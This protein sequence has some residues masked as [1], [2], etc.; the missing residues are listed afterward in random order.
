MVGKDDHHKWLVKMIA[1]NKINSMNHSNKN[2]FKALG[3]KFILV[4]K[5][6]F[7]K[8]ASNMLPWFDHPMENFTYAK[9]F[10]IMP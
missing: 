7:K 2:N 3:Q 6:T 4:T 8:T 5:L 10:V 9:P 1:I